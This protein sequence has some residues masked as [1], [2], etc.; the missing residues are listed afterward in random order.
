MG[1]KKIIELCARHRVLTL[2]AVALWVWAGYQAAQRVQVDALPDLTDTQVI[3]YS[4]WDVS[5]DIIED[6]VTYPIITGLLG[7]PK[8]KDIRGIS[9]FGASYVYAIFEDGTDLYW[10]RS[11]V[12]EYL[13]S[14]AP[15]LPAQ[16]QT[17]LGPDATGVGWILQYA[18]RDHKRLMSLDELR[19]FQD[20]FLRYALQ[21]VPGVAEVASFGGF[22]K[23]YEVQIQPDLL[24]AH[25]LSLRQVIQAI[26]DGNQET[27]ARV[28]DLS[29]TE[30]MVR[31]RGYA[32]SVEELENIVID[33][34]ANGVPIFVR[35]V[36]RVVEG[37]EMRRGL[38]D[39][40]GDGDAVGGIVVMRHGENAAA[41]IQAVRA[42]M[43]DLKAS[44][45]E[46]V[47]LLITYDRSELIGR[48]L[49]TL[50]NKT[51]VEMLVVA[52]VIFL[53]L[54]HFASSLVP[55]VI[56]PAAVLIS[57]IPLYFM[58]ISA[59]IMSLGGI[60]ISIGA[61]VDAAIVVVENCHKR[62]E[63]WRKQGQ[64]GN[65]AEVILA[66][67]QEVAPA[68]FYSLLV[69]AV[70]FLPI[71]ALE[72]QEGRLFHPLAYSKTFAMLVAALLS[73]T[74]APAVLILFASG[75]QW[76]WG[77]RWL[78]RL[79][80][81]TFHLDVR[82]EERHP[83]SRWL[84]RWYGPIVDWVVDH[85]KKVVVVA[86][87][88]LLLTIPLFQ[89]LG[90]EFMPPL[91]EG[92]VLYMPTTMPGISVEEA[93]RLL[94]KQDE[95]L[96]S[97]PFVESVHGKAGHADT[98][99]DPAPFSMMET[100]I[101]L[102]DRDHWPKKSRWYSFLP[103]WMQKLFHFTVPAVA[104][105]EELIAEMNAKMNFP[106]LSNAWTMPIRG[107]MDMLTTGIR[108]PLGI[109]VVGDNLE[110]VTQLAIRVEEILKTLPGVRSVF[111]E[112]MTGGFFLDLDFDRAA[113]ARHGISVANAHHSVQVALGGARA[114][115]TVEGRERYPI[116]VRYARDFRQTEEEIGRILLDSP[117]GYHVPLAAV[118]QVQKRAGPDMV[119]NENG[120]VTGYVLIDL[121][122]S[123]LGG[124]VERARAQLAQKLSLPKGFTLEWSGQ[125][126]SWQ[127]VQRRL[128]VVLPLTLLLVILLI[129]FN[130]RSLLKTGIILA[131]IPF[132]L[133]GAV[134]LLW[135]MDYN[136]SVAV[137]VGIVALVGLD[138]E[139]AIY[140]LLYLDLSFDRH[141]QEGRMRNLTDLRAAI[142]EGAV[143][144]IRPK[145]MTALTT[146]L[147]LL[148]VLLAT[149]A[150]TG[151]D[152][153]KRMAAPMVG[154]I[155][156]SVLLE[157][158]VY[159]AIFALWR[160]RSLT[161]SSVHR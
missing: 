145:L 51:I 118:A 104:T 106:G 43:A 67:I 14:I 115:T 41:V 127:R 107:R 45:P 56:L 16:V 130:T 138:A 123:D 42:K 91:D 132:S 120:L 18:L 71:F 99:T 36:G 110:K 12:T 105:P 49:A 100:V 128:Q 46:G 19:S 139:T 90:S 137:W 13:S 30:F 5:P 17:R 142:H 61:M 77:P 37:P 98:A 140:M 154:G 4:T 64:P 102:K 22:K 68:S 101:V 94:Q 32:R 116:E 153:M 150:E 26:Q 93:S 103:E 63:L 92:T 47:E 7:L 122:T 82:D 80:R 74:L 88:S 65:A 48:V 10:A 35:N 129:Y 81:K 126:E 146:F 57:F 97:F 40:N 149:S 156:T 121:E 70:S 75:A 144:R 50:K 152:V 124:F 95:I 114:S 89:K 55:V 148:P 159:P 72:A 52:L 11:R 15:E 31:L 147:A 54:L 73:V 34:Q 60:I 29:G 161:S 9:V 112:R 33:R 58:E 66:A 24:R 157:L 87:V 131:A 59:N 134:W 135:F 21:S 79:V 141:R 23:Q 27:G 155:F 69:I 1:L 6:Q 78:Q 133:I 117:R 119:R 84:F 136:L 86:L 38:G 39:L 3:V 151:A 83:V 20:W 28:V 160:E 143:H 113:L 44:F 62:L 111:A 158:L 108:T 109:K 25:R 53:F 125:Y 8:V 96:K 2:I 76:R 85:R